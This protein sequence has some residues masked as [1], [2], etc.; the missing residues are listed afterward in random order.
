MVTTLGLLGDL[1]CEAEQILRR[2]HAVQRCL[3]HCQ[4]I[5]LRKRLL[6]EVERHIIRCMELENL[7]RSYKNDV[8]SES[9]QLQLLDELLKRVLIN[10]TFLY[11][12]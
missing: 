3:M 5:G 11:Q 9:Y 4:D 10:K 6:S 2:M 12:S 1:C 7:V 8:F